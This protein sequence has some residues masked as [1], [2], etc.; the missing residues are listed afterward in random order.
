MKKISILCA[1]FLGIF[2]VGST[3]A[4]SQSI[5]ISKPESRRFSGNVFTSEVTTAEVSGG[6]AVSPKSMETFKKMFGNATD[7]IWTKIDRNHDRA[8]FNSNG[9][10]VRAGFDRKGK[11]MYTLRY[12][13]EEHLPKDILLLIKNTYYGKNISDVIEV[14]VDGK[15][16]YLVDLEDKTSL[17]R[18]K[19]LDDEMT[20]ES[21][22]LKR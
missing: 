9:I 6:A 1:A 3:I 7:V 22:L 21:V 13:N 8:F 12:Y 11:L 15:T 16:A 5:A 10:T 19:V 4:Y 14:S 18:I 2:L 17:L 20:E